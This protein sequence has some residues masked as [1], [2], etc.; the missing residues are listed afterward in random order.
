M[1]VSADQSPVEA[2]QKLADT[3]V[4][5]F[6]ADLPADELIP[7]ADALKDRGALVFNVS[8]PDDRLRAKI[9]RTNLFHLAPSRAMLTDALAQFLSVRHWQALFLVARPQ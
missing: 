5:L 8:A 1:I 3:G 7:V 4:G 2:A 9:C 6:I